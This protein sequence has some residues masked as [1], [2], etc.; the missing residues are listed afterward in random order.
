KN[1]SLGLALKDFSAS[2]PTWNTRLISWHAAYLD[3]KDH[4]LLGVGHGNYAFIFD[5]YFEPRFLDYSPNETYFDRAHNNLV[6]II[7]TTG[8]LGLLAYLS[9]F[10]A[11]G[12]YL[13]KAYQKKKIKSG[14]LSIFCAIII[15]Y[16]VQNLALFDAL[17]TYIMFFALL[18]MAYFYSQ[19]YSQQPKD[20]VRFSGWK[21][22]LLGGVLALFFI[23][24]I[25]C[26]N[27]QG[28]KM[29]SLTLKGYAAISEGE[30]IQGMDYYE[31]AVNLAP[32]NRDS[33]ATLVNLIAGNSQYLSYLDQKTAIKVLDMAVTFGQENVAYNPYDSMMNSQLARI[34]NLAARYNF[35]DL[36]KLNKYSA[37]AVGAIEQAIASSPKRYPLYF[38][39]ADVYLTRAEEEEVIASLNKIKELKPD[40]QEV[41]CQFANTYFFFEKYDLAY[42]FAAQCALSGK[43]KYLSYDDLIKQAAADQAKK[44]N[45]E[46]AEKLNEV[47]AK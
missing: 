21:E 37:I 24:S 42:D 38:T 36:E 46:A 39:R 41:N 25:W 1:S 47:L 44:G 43:A 34:A 7:S 30:A 14:E 5:Y 22:Y 4:P 27:V 31:R 8:T 28:F 18:G 20:E 26:L 3:F 2:N 23:A 15:A 40:N 17:V 35:R 33:R 32:Y 45:N 29:F 11:L 16:F 13:V 12:Y 6:D 10:V 19:D 9:I